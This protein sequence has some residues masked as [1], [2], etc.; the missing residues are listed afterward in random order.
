MTET[1]EIIARRRAFDELKAFFRGVGDKS[2]DMGNSAVEKRTAQRN[3]HA[4][5]HRFF[6]V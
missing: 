5:E 2:G 3:I 1:D 4:P 6:T